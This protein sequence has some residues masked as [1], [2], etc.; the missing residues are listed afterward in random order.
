MIL[1]EDRHRRTEEAGK[2]LERLLVSDPPLRK[3]SWHWMKGWYQA[4]VERT[5]PSAQVALEQITAELVDLYHHVPPP[6]ED[7]PVSVETFPVEDYVPIEDDIEWVVKRLQNHRSGAPLGM[8]TEQLKGWLAVAWKEEAKSVEIEGA[9]GGYG[10]E[11][12]EGGCRDDE[13]GEDGGPGEGGFG[14]GGCWQR[15]PHDRRWY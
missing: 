9:A 8:R 14:G 15:I 4:A 7:I 12:G 11:K 6:G 2:E 5:P 13:L 1:K 3:E 10:G